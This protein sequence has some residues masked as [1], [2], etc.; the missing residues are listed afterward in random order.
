MN[1]LRRRIVFAT[2]Q[3]SRGALFSTTDLIILFALA[4][5]IPGGYYM[6]LMMYRRRQKRKQQVEKQQTG[7]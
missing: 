2:Q 1:A 7:K 6:E 5:Y 4:L 3:P